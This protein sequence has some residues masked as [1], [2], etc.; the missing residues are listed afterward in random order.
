MRW[1]ELQLP[2]WQGRVHVWHAQSSGRPQGCSQLQP[3]PPCSG[4]AACL[5]RGA[6]AA[7]LAAAE[8]ATA[9]SQVPACSAGW[10]TWSSPGGG[11]GWCCRRAGSCAPLAHGMLA[12]ARRS[13]QAVSLHCEPQK[14][15]ADTCTSQGWHGPSWHSAWQV[16]LLSEQPSGRPHTLPHTAGSREAAHRRS[17]DVLPHA[18]CCGG[19]MAAHG[20]HGPGWHGS[21]Q[22]WAQPLPAR[23]HGP[24]QACGTMPGCSSGRT[25]E[26]QK[27]RFAGLYFC[28]ALQPGQVHTSCGWAAPL[29]V[30]QS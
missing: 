16:W 21:G 23:R 6:A 25:C 1:Q 30:R 9:C 26:P 10:C 24:P 12:T 19:A 15:V 13:G 28:S 18:H 2:A 5:A 4:V 8:A 11:A 29:A 22:G 17:N 7:P 3:R 20:G 27:H 14:H